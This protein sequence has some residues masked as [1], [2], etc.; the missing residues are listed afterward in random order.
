L[1]EKSFESRLEEAKQILEKLMNPELT[2]EESVKAY[3]AGTKALKEAQRIL[4]DAREQIEKIRE[5]E[6]DAS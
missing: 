2:L 5:K 4:E 3:E 1:E 6:G